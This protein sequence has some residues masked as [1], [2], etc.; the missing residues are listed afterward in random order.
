MSKFIKIREAGLWERLVNVDSI[1]TIE[2]VEDNKTLIRIIG[3]EQPILLEMD[4][5]DF[6]SWILSPGSVLNPTAPIDVC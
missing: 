6:T 5:L 2:E 3:F 1:S 4:Y